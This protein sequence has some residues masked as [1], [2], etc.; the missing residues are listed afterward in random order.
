MISDDNNFENKIVGPDLVLFC[1]QGEEKWYKVGG[2][3][4]LSE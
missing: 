2:S 4:D 3:I 1:A